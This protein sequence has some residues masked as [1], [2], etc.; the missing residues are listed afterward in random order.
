[1]TATDPNHY[2]DLA[3]YLAT[4]GAVG[5]RVTSW[6]ITRIDGK[7]VDKEKLNSWVAQAPV[8]KV[9][10]YG[11]K[12]RPEPEPKPKPKP[13]SEGETKPGSK[14]DPTLDSR[15]GSG[16]EPTSEPTSEPEIEPEPTKPRKEPGKERKP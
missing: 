8:D 14:P 12:A 15:S 5:K 7:V 6:D 13:D 16:S 2:E 3:P 9:I 10:M 4:E 1:V 11:T